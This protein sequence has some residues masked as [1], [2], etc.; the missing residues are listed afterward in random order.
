[1]RILVDEDLASHELMARLRKAG[2]QIETPERG[3][4]D[5]VVRDYA[6]RRGLVLLTRNASDFIELAARARA[7]HGVLVVYDEPEPA[8]NMT[9]TEIAAAMELVQKTLGEKLKD[10]TLALNTWRR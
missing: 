8:R 1:M 3:T 2:H 6:Q 4:T 5:A 9:P 10:R 7:H